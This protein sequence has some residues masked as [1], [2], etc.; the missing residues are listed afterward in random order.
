MVQEFFGKI[1]SIKRNSRVIKGHSPKVWATLAV[2]L[3]T[4]VGIIGSN[5]NPLRSNAAPMNNKDA[6]AVVIC[7]YKGFL[8]RD[9][10]TSGKEYWKRFYVNSGYNA[11]KLGANILNS[12]EGQLTAYVTSFDSFIQRTY[13]A[14]L[15]RPVSAN[16]A[17]TWRNIHLKGMSRQTIFAFIVVAGDKPWLFP[18]EEACKNYTKGGSVRPLCKAGPAGTT[19]D[20]VVEKIPE[21]NIYVNKAWVTNIN[22]LRFN[23]AKAGHYLVVFDD[24]AVVRALRNV[25]GSK[26]SPGSHRSYGDQ[27]YLFNL[28]GYPRAARPGTSMH[29]WGLAIDFRCAGRD[30]RV[31][32]MAQNGACFNWMRQNA[33]KYGVYNLPSEPWH[34]SSNGR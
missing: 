18:K 23:A 25:P 11:E 4:T 34:W 14:C 30:G 22:N 16:E 29:E 13:Q 27:S 1:Q 33:A 26:L 7:A 9:P 24:P 19:K 10:E 28:Y 5:F 17:T 21:S 31:L 2:T 3:V 15:K 12:K 32:P 8:N 20:V 6:N